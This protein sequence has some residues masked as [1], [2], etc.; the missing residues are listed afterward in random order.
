MKFPGYLFSLLIPFVCACGSNTAEKAKEK[1]VDASMLYQKKNV[2]V[3]ITPIS[4]GNFAME[5]ISNG[6]AIAANHVIIRFPVSGKIIAVNVKNGDHV[7]SGQLLARL[8]DEDQQNRLNRSKEALEKALV[9]LDDRLIDYGFRLKDSAKVPAEMM[10]MARIKSGFNSAQHDFADAKTALQKTAIYAPFGGK[11]ANLEA[12]AFNQSDGYK[13]FCTLIDD[14]K[15]RVQ[16]NVLETEFRYIKKGSE[17]EVSPFGQDVAV[18]GVVSE[19]NPQIDQNGMIQITGQ[20]DN[21]EGL[22]LNGMSVR[23]IARNNIPEKLFIPKGAVLQRQN[24]E[25]VFTYEDGRAKWNYVETG[26]QNTRFIVINAGLDKD[27]EVIFTNHET[28]AHDTEVDIDK[29]ASIKE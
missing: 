5:I 2:E 27:K 19:I 9:D 10:R 26:Q 20:V 28:L 16:F 24:R 21:R 13:E 6:K 12:S 7:S 15:L 29:K 3:G 22:L 17:I 11:I 14:S 25:V 18:K 23:V 1:P 4:T 8:N